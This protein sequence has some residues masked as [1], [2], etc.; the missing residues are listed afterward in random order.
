MIFEFMI[1]DGILVQG[2][3]EKKEQRTEHWGMSS[4]GGW[5]TKRNWV[6]RYVENEVRWHKK[7]R[8]SEKKLSNITDKWKRLRVGKGHCIG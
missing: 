5:K 1:L 6:L 4:F 3:T 2:H 7:E 8:L